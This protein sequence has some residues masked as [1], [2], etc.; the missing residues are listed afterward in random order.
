MKA[1]TLVLA[2]HGEPID[3]HHQQ[4]SHEHAGH[5]AAHKQ[6]IHAYGGN[7]AINNQRYRRRKDGAD[8]RGRGS[9]RAGEILVI[10]IFGHGLHF[11]RAQSAGVRHGGAGHARKNDAGHNVGVCQ[12]AGNPADQ[13]FSGIKDLFGDFAC[14]HQ[15]TGQDEQ[16]YGNQQEGVNAADHLL[17]DYNQRIPQRQA[18]QHSRRT[19]GNADWH[20]NNQQHKECDQ[21]QRHLASPP[22]TAV[23]ESPFASFMMRSTV[24]STDFSAIKAPAR[25]MGIY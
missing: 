21:K 12:A 7:A 20:A 16:R 17:A 2:A 24:S 22:F 13:F 19:D 1:G 9:H 23:S 14:V 10:T 15:V 4:D 25:P 3:H 5:H 11:N 6:L 18:A 8:H